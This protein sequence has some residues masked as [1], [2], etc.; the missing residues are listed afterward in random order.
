[1]TTLSG[2]NQK[3]N[4]FIYLSLTF[5]I[6]LLEGSGLSNRNRQL[7]L[8]D[9]SDAD[10]DRV[11]DALRN[12]TNELET[13]TGDLL[14]SGPNSRSAFARGLSVQVL[15]AL[16]SSGSPTS[17]GISFAVDGFNFNIILPRLRDE[18]L[19]LGYIRRTPVNLPAERVNSR[20]D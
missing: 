12:A 16:D 13:I 18:L 11:V 6:S 9:L 19:N 10:S 20:L 3:H 2:R 17:R 14:L 7:A 8:L 15:P 4:Y 1:M 5:T